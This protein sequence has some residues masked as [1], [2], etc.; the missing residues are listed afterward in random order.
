MRTIVF[1]GLYWGTLILGNYHIVYRGP[2][3][4]LLRGITRS[5]DH[6]SHDVLQVPSS[7]FRRE[8]SPVRGFHAFL[9]QLL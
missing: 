1:W 7:G 6:S 2:L 4:G 3:L 5:L 9:A 8:D